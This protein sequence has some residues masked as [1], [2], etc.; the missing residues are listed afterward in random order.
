MSASV[1]TSIIT[2]VLLDAV[3]QNNNLITFE[4]TMEKKTFAQAIAE[5]MQ[6]ID[7]ADENTTARQLFRCWLDGSYREDDSLE[8]HNSNK[9]FVNANYSN[10]KKL[11][12]FVVSEFTKNI[13]VDFG[14]SIST[15]QKAIV[16]SLP[17]DELESFTQTLV[18]DA[19]LLLGDNVCLVDEDA[20]VI[21]EHEKLHAQWAALQ[22]A[23]LR[24]QV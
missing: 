5:S 11:R 20:K 10:F 18:H 6:S 4:V 23:K 19:R 24:H 13:A 8:F 3:H 21:F 17:S 16:K 12:S 7:I 15:A 1:S 14:C 22:Q 2:V 9:D